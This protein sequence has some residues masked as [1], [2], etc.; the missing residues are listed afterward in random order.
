MEESESTEPP[1]AGSRL[2]TWRERPR[3]SLASS[4]SYVAA[5]LLVQ[6]LSAAPVERVAIEVAPAARMVRRVVCMKIFLVNARSGGEGEG[7][8]AVTGNGSEQPLGVVVLGVV[9]DGIGGAL[10]RELGSTLLFV[11][12][13]HAA[14]DLLRDGEVV[15]DEE[16]G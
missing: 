1:S 3:T 5:E 15:G 10:R 16:Q 2:V 11:T 9:E 14:G 6:L 13:D 4:R 8:G 12:H 7:K